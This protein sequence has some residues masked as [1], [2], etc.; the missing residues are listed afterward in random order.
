MTHLW[1]KDDIIHRI[2]SRSVKCANGCI[3]YQPGKLKHKYGLVSLTINGK[4]K[5]VP[6]HRALW[7]ATHE[8]WTLPTG[9]VIRHKCDNE[10]CVNIDHLLDG[11]HADNAMDRVSRGRG[12]TSYRLHTRQRVLDDATV[13]AIRNATGK[14][15]WIADEFNVSI[16]YASK[17]RSH[18]AKTLVT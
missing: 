14:L 1:Y 12:A 7:M 17:L 6:A 10:R 8:A 4:R 2:T 5:N 16:G 15:A 9:V 3:E 13:L 18:K 11:T